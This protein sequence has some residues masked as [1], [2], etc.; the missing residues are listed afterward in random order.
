MAK[1]KIIKDLANNS[2]SIITALKRTKVLLSEFG[3]DEL[4]SWINNEISGYPDGVELPDYRC[5]KGNI[6]GSYFKGSLASHVTWTNVPIPLGKMPHEQ[7]EKLLNI[8]FREGI[9]SLKI[10]LNDSSEKESRLG[11]PVPADYYPYIAK[12]NNDLYMM[13]ISARVEIGYQNVQN[14]ISVVENRL[15]DI[16]IYLEKEFGN[17]DELDLDVDS[18]SREEKENIINKLQI[19]IYDQRVKIGDGNTIKGS[20]IASELNE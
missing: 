11:K 2:V 10:L 9:E 7:K 4:I 12:C 1:S 8:S 16:L 5:V 13:I 15:L 17:L 18:K 19:I 3:N 20:K 6:V 14:I